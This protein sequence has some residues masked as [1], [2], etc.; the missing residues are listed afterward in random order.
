MA[1][2]IVVFPI[3]NGDFPFRYVKLPEGN[4]QMWFVPRTHGY[5]GWRFTVINQTRVGISKIEHRGSEHD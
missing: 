2:E 3:N 1:I 4:T 5:H